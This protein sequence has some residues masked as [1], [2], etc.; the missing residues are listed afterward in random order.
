MSSRD[1]TKPSWF[2]KDTYPVLARYVV[3]NPVRARMVRTPGDWPWSSDRAMI[4]DA[5]APQWLETRMIPSAFGDEEAPALEH[6]SRFVAEGN[7]QPSPWKHLRNQVFLGSEAFAETMLGRIPK[8]RD[9]RELPQA[10][11]RPPAKS[12]ADY[13]RENPERNDSIVA[14]YRSGGY[15]L[16]DIGDFFS[17]HYS[18]ISKIIHAADLALREEKGKT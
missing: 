4:G 11:Q 1:A 17:L 9:L 6:Y 5:Q 14:A 8:D 2:R 18:R 12:L 16:R 3:L 15:T 7:G 13:V 10:R